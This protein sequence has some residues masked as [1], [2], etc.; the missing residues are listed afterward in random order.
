MNNKEKLYLAKVASAF[1][2]QA[3]DLTMLGTGL[4]GAGA[5]GLS[6]AA[7]S[8]LLGEEEDSVWDGAISGGMTGGLAGLVL[9]PVINKMYHDRVPWTGETKS[10]ADTLPEGYREKAVEAAKDYRA[11]EGSDLDFYQSLAD[12][13][14]DRQ[15]PVARTGRGYSKPGLPDGGWA[16]FYDPGVDKIVLNEGLDEQTAAGLSDTLQHELI[17]SQQGEDTSPTKGF[18][19]AH[20]PGLYTADGPVGDA[21]ASAHSSDRYSRTP[22]ERFSELTNQLSE[23]SGQPGLNDFDVE[24]YL[25]YLGTPEEVEAYLGPLKRDYFKRT[26]KLIDTPEA[27]QKLLM[28]IMSDE[29]ETATENPLL[30]MVKAIKNLRSTKDNDEHYNKIMRRMAEIMPG[31]V[32]QKQGP[33]QPMS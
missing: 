20:R 2:D 27:G 10:T 28:D 31:L 15:V 23:G 6:G 5:G 33:T 21:L 1:T 30:N 22:G 26:G 4:I 11:G 32:K 29:Y 3:G 8:G 12:E 16:G 7:L 25:E 18:Q 9:N 24:R 19:N 13:S 17:H 14:L